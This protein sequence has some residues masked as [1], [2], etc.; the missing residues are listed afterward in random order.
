MCDKP[1]VERVPLYSD[2]SNDEEPY[3]TLGS[4]ADKKTILNNFF[5]GTRGLLL[6][7]HQNLQACVGFD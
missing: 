4:A 3:K 6:I 2:P 7:K 1:E 5:L